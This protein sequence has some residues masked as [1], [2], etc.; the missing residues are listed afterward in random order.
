MSLTT[1]SEPTR[2]NEQ[3]SNQHND[4]EIV[5]YTEQQ[6]HHSNTNPNPNSNSN[7]ISLEHGRAQNS[8]KDGQ[9]RRASEMVS[10]GE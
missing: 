5:D 1:L 6:L 4:V 10:T 9:H 8:N 7:P 2:N 3:T